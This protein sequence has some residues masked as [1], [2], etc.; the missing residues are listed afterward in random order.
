MILER[1]EVAY[2]VCLLATSLTTWEW[3]WTIVFQPSGH[4]FTFNIS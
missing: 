1:Q 2:V 3:H 4:P